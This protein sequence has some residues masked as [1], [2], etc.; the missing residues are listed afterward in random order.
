MLDQ[1]PLVLDAPVGGTEKR[2]A[3]AEKQLL[4]ARE[5]WAEEKY[6][7]QKEVRALAAARRE[8]MLELAQADEAKLLAQ[9][10]TETAEGKDD[11]R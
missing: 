7:E 10:A 11:A 3:A 5:A 9:K 1:R 2:V 8:A 4:V 6:A